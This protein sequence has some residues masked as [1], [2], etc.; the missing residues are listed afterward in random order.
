VPLV[1]CPHR[2]ACPVSATR[3]ACGLRTQ[4]ELAVRQGQFQRAAVERLLAK[5]G[6]PMTPASR[7]MTGAPPPEKLPW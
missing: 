6:V 1:D 3:W 7:V 4:F 2:P 5:Y